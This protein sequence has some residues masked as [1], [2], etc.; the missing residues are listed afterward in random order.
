VHLPDFQAT[1]TLSHKG[2]VET[3]TFVGERASTKKAAEQSAAAQALAALEMG[4]PTQ[5]FGAPVVVVNL[6][7]AAAVSGGE[8]G[9]PAAVHAQVEGPPAPMEGSPDGNKGT[10]ITTLARLFRG[11]AS[12]CYTSVNES[13]GHQLSFQ[14]MLTVSHRGYLEDATFLGERESTKKASEQSA[15]AQAL[16]A[17]ETRGELTEL[18]GAPVLFQHAAVTGGGELGAPSAALQSPVE[19]PPT[20]DGAEEAVSRMAV[21]PASQTDNPSNLNL[22]P[23][24]VVNITCNGGAVQVDPRSIPS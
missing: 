1:L 24:C 11:E 13:A 18:F 15:A 9:V 8:Q 2:Y 20:R 12:L 10:L 21:S 17:L 4:D 5:L 22:S 23:D 16:A 7:Q 14:R 19:E 6:P 3:K